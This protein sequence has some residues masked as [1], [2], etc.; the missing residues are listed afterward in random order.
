MIELLLGQVPM[1]RDFPAHDISVIAGVTRLLEF[2]D[3][4]PIIEQGEKPRAA[5]ILLDGQV[6]VV[7]R[8]PGGGRTR[9]CVLEP[10]VLFGTVALIDGGNRSAGCVALGHVRVAELSADDFQRLS[11]AATPLGT[12]FQLAVVRQLIRDLRGTNSRIA[13]LASFGSVGAEELSSTL[14]GLA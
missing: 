9:L 7:R 13:E 3:G 6:E 11:A 10:G 1:L 8:L 2:T 4:T 12:R 14:S 5:Y